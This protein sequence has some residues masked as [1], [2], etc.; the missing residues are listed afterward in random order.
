MFDNA[1]TRNNK[2]ERGKRQG[3]Q[4]RTQR[5]ADRSQT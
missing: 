4:T 1:S 5:H 3:K 2:R